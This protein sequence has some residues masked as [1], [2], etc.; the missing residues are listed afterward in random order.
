M[1]LQSQKKRQVGRELEAKLPGI[2]KPLISRTLGIGERNLY[3]QNTRQKEADL[4]LKDQILKVLELNPSYGHR[5]VALALGIGKKRTRR[6]MRLFGIKPYKRKAR[7]TK[8][9]DYG[10]PPSGIPNLIKGSCPVKP[11]VYFAGD[12]TRLIWN[13]KIIHLATFI[14]LF[15]REIVGW[16]VSIRHTS[17]FVIEAFLDAVRNAGLPLIVHTDQGSEYNSKEY[18]KFMESLGV[19]VS[20]SAKASPWENGYQ[21]SFYDNF[22]TDLG[23][24]FERFET[25]GE[26]VEALHSTINYYNNRRIHTKLKTSPLKFKLEFLSRNM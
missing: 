3:N 17:E 21:E 25:I 11:N 19:K 2:S 7:W 23:A 12:F 22:K 1:R 4:A 26:F 15:T 20:M 6:V 10:N 5:R 8:K 13:Q 9:K 16:S 24:E 18:T 14:D